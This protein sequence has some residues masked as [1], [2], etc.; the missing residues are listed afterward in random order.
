LLDSW[1]KE[2]DHTVKVFQTW[3]D[4]RPHFERHLWDAVRRMI[5]AYL[6]LSS[7]EP[8]PH[9]AESVMQE[10]WREARGHITGLGLPGDLSEASVHSWV[11]RLTDAYGNSTGTDS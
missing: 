2:C 10:K 4:L 8:Q 5:D 9:G 6:Q 3:D 1:T 11:G 7:P